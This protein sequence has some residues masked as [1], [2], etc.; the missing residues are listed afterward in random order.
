MKIRALLA[1]FTA[2]VLA[3]GCVDTIIDPN[4][5][6][7]DRNVVLKIF[8]YYDG[9]LLSKDTLYTLGQAELKFTDIRFLYTGYTFVSTSG[10]T[11][12]RDT[13]V[14][15]HSF[16]TNSAFL[17]KIPT[18]AYNGSHYFTLGM[19]TVNAK[20]AP[21]QF[22]EGH[23]LRDGVLYRGAGKGYN[24]MYFSGVMRKVGDTLAPT[25]PFTIAVATPLLNTKFER[26]MGFSV[27]GNRACNINVVLNIDRLLLG[28]DPWQT[29][30]IASDPTKPGDF[31][32]SVKIK[33]NLIPAYIIQI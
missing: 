19:D 3:A 21:G 30:A 17:T 10:D 5:Q 18:G 1:F 16:G 27:S 22:P 26:K 28:I 13:T 7:E 33:Q 12:H 24:H 11:L 25:K 15:I 32:E 14:S 29:P 31:A 9:E 4:E 8:S 20:L 23:P 6:M 2:S